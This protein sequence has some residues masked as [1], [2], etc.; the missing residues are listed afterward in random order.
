MK[1]KLWIRVI[2]LVVLFAWPT[3]EAWRL[4]QARQQLAD[5]EQLA[6][7]VVV[8]LQVAKAR[9]NATVPYQ[10]VSNPRH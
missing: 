7:S 9:H 8:K 2:V 10:P 3:V 6:Q 4:F 1:T 5:S